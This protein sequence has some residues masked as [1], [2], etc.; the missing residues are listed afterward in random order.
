MLSYLLE[1]LE[2]S[3]QKMSSFYPRWQA[4]ISAIA[5]LPNTIAKIG[6]LAMPDN[7]FGW[8]DPETR[9]DPEIFVAAQEKWY[10]HTIEAFGPD[11]CMFESNFPVD[12]LSLDY[13]TYWNG[14]RMMAERY[15]PAEQ[16]DLFAG[17]AAR[18]YSLE[19]W[20]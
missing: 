5:A 10:H 9:P 18:V 7:G 17:T 13:A 6:G 11:R 2:A 8:M 19:G 16:H 20:T 15:D 1:R 3:E 14:C 4:D 12:S